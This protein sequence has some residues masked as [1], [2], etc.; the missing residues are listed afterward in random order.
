MDI[1]VLHA[2][3]QHL[4]SPFSTFSVED[5]A[6]L[7]KWQQ[8]IPNR[9]LE[10]S[11]ENGCN[12]WL[13]AG[14]LF[15]GDASI[16]TVTE[17][18]R[19]F[20]ECSVPVMISPGNHDSFSSH[21]PWTRFQWPENVHVFDRETLQSIELPE[22]NC[23]V[24]GAAFLSMDSGSI[25][26]GFTLDRK[27][28]HELCVLH[29]DAVNMNS[30]YN[31][32]N[33][34]QVRKSGFDYIALGHIHNRG[35]FQAGD[36]V[37]GWPGC[38]MG[39]GWDEKGDK[40]VY[41]CNIAERVNLQFF[42]F[43]F[44]GFFELE[45]TDPD[46]LE[47]VLPRIASDDYFRVTIHGRKAVNLQD[48]Y[49]RYSHLKHISFAD[50]TVLPTDPWENAAGNSFKGVFFR[51]L[52]EEYERADPEDRELIVMA[53]QVSQDILNGLEVDLT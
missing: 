45:V 53:A 9:L 41:I 3:D 50:R 11:K 13:L 51:M 47:T 49:S 38:P 36:T 21:S 25:L 35:F 22:L 12:L 33:S 5:R 39:R 7:K 42:D 43:S 40:G 23:R 28:E 17:L 52:H 15:D 34:S 8:K 6:E 30:P 44:P 14:D 48:L 32:V 10:I 46:E 26:E 16:A 2:A 31:P 29:G 19:V 24:W 27:Y 20:R 18:Q 37:C 1:K 4:D